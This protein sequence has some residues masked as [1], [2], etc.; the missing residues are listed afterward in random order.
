MKGA[1]YEMAQ[2]SKRHLWFASQPTRH[3]LFRV[4]LDRVDLVGCLYFSPPRVFETLAPISHFH[5][6]NPPTLAHT[7]FKSCV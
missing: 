6:G 2:E 4:G 7:G 5:E 1:T 3:S